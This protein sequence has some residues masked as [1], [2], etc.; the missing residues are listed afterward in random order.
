MVYSL[1][2]VDRGILRLLQVDARNVT[3]SEMADETGVA[4]STVR[5][6][7]DQLE[8]AG[9]IRG[10]RP[11]IDHEAAGFPI[12]VLFVVTAPPTEQAGVVER[13]LDV[14]GVVD[15]T[16]TLTG[17][18]NVYVEVVA[19]STADV[20]RATDA[21]HDLGVEVESSEIVKR[22]EVKPFNHP[23]YEGEPLDE[24]ADED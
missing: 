5:N 23:H 16:Q 11:E 14:E 21:I 1:D 6:R 2:D 7:I 20:T 15:V 10:Y 22:R 19:T 4:A 3:A 8:T 9:V 18:Q 17:R 12:R 13:L 24:E